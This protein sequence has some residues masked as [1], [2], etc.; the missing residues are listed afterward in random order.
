MDST[1]KSFS[2][3]NISKFLILGAALFSFSFNNISLTKYNFLL[4]QA[5]FYFLVPAIFLCFH[6]N[7]K[8]LIYF[9]CFVIYIFMSEMAFC[10]SD[11]GICGLR[12]LTGIASI[13]FIFMSIETVAFAIKSSIVNLKEIERFF[14]YS[15]FIIIV[16][17]IPDIIAINNGNIQSSL[18]EGRFHFLRY[19]NDS[20]YVTPRLRG[21]TQEPSYLGMVI[22]TIYPFIF[23]NYIKKFSFF[24][25]FLFFGIWVCLLFSLSKVGILTCLFLTFF[26]ITIN[27][28]NKLYALF[29]VF[30]PVALIS[31]IIPLDF[32]LSSNSLYLGQWSNSGVDSS[33][34]MRFG[35]ML[36]ALRLF[37]ENPLIGVGLGQSGFFIPKYYPDWIWTSPEALEYSQ[38]SYY[39]AT[40]TF[41]F[42]PKL[43]AE[44]GLIGFL[45]FGIRFL[46]LTRKVYM[47]NHSNEVKPF[48]YSF[49][50]F[51]I[52]SFGVEGFAYIPAWI[53]L[54][55]VI[56]TLKKSSVRQAPSLSLL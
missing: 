37:F 54:G 45:F 44:L 8:S 47:L 52:S 29:I 24:S 9:F 46:L 19:Y 50:G 4:G 18:F 49:I 51:L 32:L 15:A 39:G 36:A 20:T 3:N 5:S 41:S 16:C 48:Y 23:N 25:F 34:V 14:M 10:F 6:F 11:N 35:S 13:A 43:L 12:P 22:S 55:V 30:V 38:A 53:V 21:F 17:A 56:G 2:I 27:L 42:I 1:L 33:S 26:L 31:L 7:K 40:P 28:K